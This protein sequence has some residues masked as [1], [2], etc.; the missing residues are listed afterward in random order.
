LVLYEDAFSAA[1]CPANHL[2][3][4]RGGVAFKRV[5]RKIHLGAS[6]FLGA[7]NMPIYPP[8]GKIIKTQKRP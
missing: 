8:A 3:M 2:P 1:H 7:P 5:I 4:N 6:T